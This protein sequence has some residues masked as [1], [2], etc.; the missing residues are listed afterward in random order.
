MP[1]ISNYSLNSPGDIIVLEHPSWWTFQRFMAALGGI[2]LI[3]AGALTL[4]ILP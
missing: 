3:L 2:M 1:L 4:D